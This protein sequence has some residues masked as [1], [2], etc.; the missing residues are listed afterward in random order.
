MAGRSA[1]QQNLLGLLQMMSSNPALAQLVNWANFAR[2]AFEL[3]DFKNVDELL[4]QQVPMV[5][6]IAQE[7]GQSPEGVAQM[8]SSQNLPQLDPAL[9]AILGGQ[10]PGQMQLAQ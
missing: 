1:R 10:N 6:Q 4:V 2:Q 8:A 3:F 7:T 9:L 5:N